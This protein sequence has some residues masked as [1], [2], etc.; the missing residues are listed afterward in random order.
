MFSHGQRGGDR[1]VV[2]VGIAARNRIP[3]VIIYGNLH[4]IP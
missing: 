1:V 2:S 4:T 3:V